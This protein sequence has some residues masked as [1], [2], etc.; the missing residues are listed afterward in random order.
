MMPFPKSKSTFWCFSMDFR[1][2]INI[3]T[4]LDTRSPCLL[5]LSSG[6]FLGH[7]CS[8]LWTLFSPLQATQTWSS[9][10]QYWL[11]QYWREQLISAL[12][13]LLPLRPCPPFPM[14]AQRVHLTLLGSRMGQTLANETQKRGKARRLIT[15]PLPPVPVLRRSSFLEPLWKS[16]PITHLFLFALPLPFCSP[17]LHPGIAPFNKVLSWTMC[18]CFCF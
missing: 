8:K 11:K 5:N 2:Q 10:K 15:S 3:T 16:L 4:V 14:A 1:K 12:A 13:G 6:H 17:H 7:S 18:L 9:Y